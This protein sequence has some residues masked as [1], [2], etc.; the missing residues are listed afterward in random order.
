MRAIGG[1]QT[2][3]SRLSYWVNWRQAAF[4]DRILTAAPALAA[5]APE[6]V[7][8][9]S[10]LDSAE[11]QV[12]GDDLLPAVGLGALTPKL[13]AFWP[14][15]LPVWDGVALLHGGVPGLL[16]VQGN[17]SPEQMIARRGA[18]EPRHLA[19]LRPSVEEA[20]GFMGA[21]GAGWLDGDGADLALRLTLLYWLNQIARVPTFLALVGFVGE[22][23]P[24]ADWR[25]A[26]SGLLNG[27]GLGPGA[28][29]ID[30]IALVWAP[31][32]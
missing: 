14:G 20:E 16:L 19:R 4:N 25:A 32:E 13:K 23:A 17:A 18:F 6:R 26:L 30:R 2:A 15:P 11:Y 24:L 9:R 29:L 27:M 5:W 31:E 28:P 10:P 12:F 7:E 3:S 21:R 22:A 1:S 8:W